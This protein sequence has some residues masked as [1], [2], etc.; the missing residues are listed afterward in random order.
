[1]Q[2][3]ELVSWIRDQFACSSDK[4]FKREDYEVVRTPNKKWF[5]LVME[6]PSSYLVREL[7]GE[8]ALEFSL[9]VNVKVEPE[10]ISALCAMEGIYPAYHMSKTNWVSLVVSS[11]VL[12]VANLGFAQDLIAKSFDLV[13]RHKK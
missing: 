4:P 3:E 7:K 10:D 2:A 5:A 11:D 9:V 6:I 8:P 1:M 12:P 13:Y